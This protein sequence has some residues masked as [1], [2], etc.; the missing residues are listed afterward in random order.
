MDGKYLENV[1]RYRSSAILAW[2]RSQVKTRSLSKMQNAGSSYNEKQ[3]RVGFRLF[4][5]TI[6]VLSGFLR[7]IWEMI[8]WENTR[9]AL[10]K[11]EELLTCKVWYVFFGAPRLSSAI[12][13]QECLRYTFYA[14]F[15]FIF[16]LVPI[17]CLILVLLKLVTTFSV[18]TYV[19]DCIL[20]AE[21]CV[22]VILNINA[23][24]SWINCNMYSW[25]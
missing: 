10:G 5:V 16:L 17:L 7:K 2:L 20:W 6:E 8:G 11:L 12:P 3:R 1:R 22:K 4:R 25:M 21:S 15:T 13:Q 23:L 14:Y 9:S 18:G 24:N 19:N